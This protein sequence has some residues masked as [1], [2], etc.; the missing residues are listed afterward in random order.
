[1]FKG[2]ANIAQLMKQAS[3]I[4]ARM[5]EMKQKLAEIRTEGTAGAGEV[6]VEA[7]GDQRVLSCRISP[8]LAASGDVGRLERLVTEAVNDALH[9]ARQIAAQQMA[10]AAGDSGIPGL[11]DAVA[12]FG[13]G[14]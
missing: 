12:K 9:K 5:G 1:M 13:L 6:T 4:Q 10:G 11:G 7:T 2:L 14:Q 8:A 3:D